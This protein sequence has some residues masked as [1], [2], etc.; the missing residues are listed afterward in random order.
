VAEP[1][2]LAG[3]GSSDRALVVS[4]VGTG[5]V[6]AGDE[7]QPAAPR[8][9]AVAKRLNA[10]AGRLAAGAVV[11]VRDLETAPV[12]AVAG[13]PEPLLQ[14]TE[15][16]AQAYNEP[17]AR[18][19]RGGGGPPVTRERLARWWGAVLADLALVLARGQAPSQAVELASEGRALQQLHQAA[20]GR[21]P[22]DLLARRG[23]LRESLR[24]LGLRVPASVSGTAAATAPAGVAAASGE[25]PPG[26]FELDGIWVGATREAGR[27]RQFSVTF[28]GGGGSLT[29]MGGV[30]LSQ[31]L[32]SA[33][34]NANE[35]SFAI[36]RGGGEVH[37]RGT[38]DGNKLSGAISSKA[39]GGG[40]V[41]TF[42]LYRR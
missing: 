30:D 28:K 15:A 1:F 23:P 5:L 13:D 12:I 29:Y 36:Q 27:R 24:A 32:V 17:W 41:G 19:S 33:S 8:A 42:E 37:Y 21:P 3:A 26:G 22:R 7:T 40:D 31:P 20:G 4:D 11:E 18:P 6:L 25:T 10:A 39:A 14:V 35:V 2:T 38:W 34:R 16:D 9:V